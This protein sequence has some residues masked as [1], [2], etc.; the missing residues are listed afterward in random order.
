MHPD[1]LEAL[2]IATHRLTQVAARL[3]GDETPSAAW[4]T[5]SLLDAEGALRVGEVA[6]V[7]RITQPGASRMIGI[8][9]ADGY[10]ERIADPDARASRV[11]ITPAGLTALQRWR[12]RL[13]DEMAP[14]FDTLTAD[15]WAAL[16]RTSDLLLERT[17]ARVDA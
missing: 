3:T 2:L 17:R 12:H 4:R 6:A 1:V 14:L 16:R 15:D 13:G 7:A 10:V 8:L 5:L 11:A 9:E